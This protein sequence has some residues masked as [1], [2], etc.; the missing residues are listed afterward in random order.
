VTRESIEEEFS[1]R[2]TTL[3]KPSPIPPPKRVW[4]EVQMTRIRL[5]YK[6]QAME[7]KWHGFTE[8]DHMT[9]LRSW[10]GFSVYEA[11]FVPHGSGW[12]LA[13]SVVESDL[14]FYY[15]GTDAFETVSIERIV[16]GMLLGK[17]DEK[18]E[19]RWQRACTRS[20]AGP[21]LV[22]TNRKGPQFRIEPPGN[23][24]KHGKLA[25]Q[26]PLQ[27]EAYDK[28]FAQG[29]TAALG[30]IAKKGMNAQ[31]IYYSADQQ[32]A[33]AL[34]T[35]A[36]ESSQ[37]AGL[38]KGAKMAAYKYSREVSQAVASEAPKG[39]AWTLIS[40]HSDAGLSAALNDLSTDQWTEIGSFSGPMTA[41]DQSTLFSKQ[42]DPARAV[43]QFVRFWY[44]HGLVIDF[45]W[46]NWPRFGKGIEVGHP[47]TIKK[48]RHASAEDALRLATKLLRSENFDEGSLVRALESGLLAAVMDRL[49]RWRL[50]TETGLSG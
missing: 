6:A 34:S 11:D 22:I 47:V 21:K 36:I 35:V 14:D 9:L 41:S 31:D 4:S 45:P 23:S 43:Q 50:P 19:R 8:G 48:L 16:V 1:Y 39:A 40:D 38:A 37:H 10:T 26:H 17:Y 28:F 29:F 13:N 42:S 44:D 18:V 5:G 15:R 24:A 12:Q 2:V 20:E 30:A 25:D 49:H 7:E 3:S 33:L 32:E 46:M 27:R